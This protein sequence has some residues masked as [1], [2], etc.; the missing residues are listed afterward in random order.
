MKK[1]LYYIKLLLLMF[2]IG[3]A[4]SAC[5]DHDD[6]KNSD[7]PELTIFI[8]QPYSGL[9]SYLDRDL[10]EV[11]TALLNDPE[12][13]NKVNILFFRNNEIKGS[14]YKKVYHFAKNTGLAYIEDVLQKE[15]PLS[16]TDY[17]TF[18]GL[19]QILSDVISIGKTDKYGMVIGCHANGWIPT[20]EDKSSR[21]FD[22]IHTDTYTST[23]SEARSKRKVFGRTNND[24]YDTTY[25]TLGKAIEA[26]GKKFEFILIDDC[27]SQNIEVAYDLRNAC[28]YLIGSVTEI[29]ADGQ[30]YDTAIPNLFA[31]NYK[32]I[33]D[34][35]Y[36]F[37]TKPGNTWGTATLSVI[38]CSQTDQ[39]A[40]IM[41]R[42]YSNSDPS[43]V[44]RSSVQVLDGLDHYLY[45]YNFFYD[46]SDYVHQLCKDKNLIADY[47]AQLKK[48][49]IYNV[50]TPEFNSAYFDGYYRDGK[51]YRR[52]INT[53]CG[54]S[55][56]DPCTEKHTEWMD[57]SWY[58][59]TH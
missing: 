35:T 58:K 13:C 48:L 54:I 15:Y 55:C 39:M 40:A 18:S 10:R 11:N 20:T 32:A 53:C 51:Q 56:S 8:H 9:E 26:T 44:K 28:N 30:S 37:Y 25:K 38:D 17:T 23:N 43:E 57:T 14:L 12:L 31:A 27:N 3:G 52:P 46:F 45:G 34:D 19:N 24:R 21:A 6:E 59:A 41:K 42:I 33:C 50:F 16:Q 1:S 49:V 22:N 5:K 2:C 4:V 47:E 29:G 7:K 36:T